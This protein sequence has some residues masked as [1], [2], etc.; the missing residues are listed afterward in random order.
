MK[1]EGC[2]VLGLEFRVR[3]HERVLAKRVR[4]KARHFLLDA[5]ESALGVEGVGFKIWG[6]GSRA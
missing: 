5:C 4:V 6:S 1:G 3:G 2:R